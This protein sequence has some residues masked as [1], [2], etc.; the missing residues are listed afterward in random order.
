[1]AL[2]FISLNNTPN[3]MALSTDIVD[4]AIAGAGVGGTIYLTDTQAW[5]IVL[6]D[7]TLDDYQLPIAADSGGGVTR[8]GAT[9]DG[10]LAVWNGSSA[11]SIKDG[12]A[13][14][15]S[16]PPSGSAGG[17]LSGSYPNPTLASTPTAITPTSITGCIA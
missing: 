16:L 15:T 4:N 3:Y 11:D 6:A 13:V 12:G 2:T 7:L 8:S 5:K 17:A 10:H 14:P 9:T 1:M